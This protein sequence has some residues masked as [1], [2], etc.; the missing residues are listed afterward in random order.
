M[1]VTTAACQVKSKAIIPISGK[2]Y[3]PLYN[4]NNVSCYLSTAIRFS[5][6]TVQWSD[7]EAIR[8]M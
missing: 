8:L 1:H 6:V 2:V 4:N 3:L 7:A 5:Q